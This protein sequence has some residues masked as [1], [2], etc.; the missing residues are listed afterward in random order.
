[1]RQTYAASGQV[2]ALVEHFNARLRFEAAD[3]LMAAIERAVTRIEAEP[4]GGLPA[5]RPY[6]NLARLGFRWTKEHR[7]WF[8]W[9][10]AGGYPVLT[11][12][13]HDTASIESRVASDDDDELPL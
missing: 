9:S 6:P 3:K 13:F 10:M 2:Q 12:V 11:N 8:G 4:H 1:M 5:P 7:Y